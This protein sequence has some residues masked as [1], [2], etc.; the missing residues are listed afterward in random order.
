M[1]LL[2]NR[3]LQQCGEMSVLLRRPDTLY[4][5][6][7]LSGILHKIQCILH[8]PTSFLAY[9]QHLTLSITP[10][11]FDVQ[12]RQRTQRAISIPIAT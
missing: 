7:Q 9:S 8:L 1:Y 12:A 2:L 11:T 4:F 6:Q 3:R 5:P 10:I